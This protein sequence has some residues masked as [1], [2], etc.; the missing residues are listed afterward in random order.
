ML[1]VLKSK[2]RSA[3]MASSSLPTVAAIAPRAD[4]A[5]GKANEEI[6]KASAAIAAK[7]KL[8]SNEHDSAAN[9][10]RLVRSR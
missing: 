3:R 10:R 9:M 2:F 6:A 1:G 4:A 7:A 8:N 5:T